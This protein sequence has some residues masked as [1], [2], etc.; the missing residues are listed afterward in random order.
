MTE[1]CIIASRADFESGVLLSVCFHVWKALGLPS[2]E[3]NSEF[4]VSQAVNML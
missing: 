1:Y 2:T 3:R 4:Y